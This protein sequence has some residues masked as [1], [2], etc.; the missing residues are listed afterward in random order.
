MAFDFQAARSA[1]YSDA[2]IASH[3]AKESGSKFDVDG[4]LKAGYT[5]EEIAQHLA[6]SKDRSFTSA[7][8]EGV[9]NVLAGGAETAEQLIGKT[10]RGDKIKAA[11][12]ALRPDG[13]ENARLYS[14]KEGFTPSQAPRVIAENAPQLAA[15]I[16]AYRLGSRAHPVAG[17]LAAGAA[18]LGMNYGNEVKRS[19]EARA[20]GSA[21]E[22]QDRLR[23]AA[24]S[25][26]AAALDVYGARGLAARNAAQGLGA[27][28]VANA[29]GDLAMKVGREAGTEAAQERLQQVGRTIGTEGGVRTSNE[30]LINAGLSG[31]VTAGAIGASRAVRDANS[32]VRLRE[33][34][35]DNA[36]ASTAVAE[37][38]RA[39][40]G[41]DL[42][43]TRAAAKAV[44][45]VAMD[46]RTELQ[47]EAQAA[48]QAGTLPDDTRAALR[49]ATAGRE[50]NEGDY[51]TL[52]AAPA[53]IQELARQSSVLARLKTQNKGTEDNFKGGLSARA[54]K[55]VRLIQNPIGASTA[56]GLGAL[57]LASNAAA[58]FT[59]GPASAAAIGAGYAGARALDRFTG[60]R[61]PVQRFA[62]RFPNAYPPAAA[63]PVVVG[64]P[65]PAPVQPGPA[66]VVAGGPQPGPAPAAPLAPPPVGPWN[67]PPRPNVGTYGKAPRPPAPA[68]PPPAPAPVDPSVLSPEV[69]AAAK[70]TAWRMKMREQSQAA[71]AKAAG[72]REAEALAAT[73]P[74]LE[75]VGGAQ[76]V[77]NPAMG[78][79]LREYISTA[80]AKKKITAQPEDDT[81]AQAEAILAGDELPAFL[82]L[83]ERSLPPA[84]TARQAVMKVTKSNGKVKEKTKTVAVPPQE[85]APPPVVEQALAPTP[86]APL[87]IPPKINGPA[88]AAPPM[89]GL[90]LRAYQAIIDKANAEGR[91][92]GDGRVSPA[93][94][95]EKEADAIVAKIDADDKIRTTTAR[96]KAGVVRN[97]TAVN[98]AVRNVAKE[99]GTPAK[100]LSKLLK[101]VETAKGARDALKEFTAKYPQA[102]DAVK[103]YF[104]KDMV[105]VVW[106]K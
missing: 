51:D 40:S 91:T 94:K 74:M 93:P 55:T 100:E 20:P 39:A 45:D 57:G 18:S 10:E 2:E 5:A 64:A 33:F 84:I 41:D 73:S 98:V 9:G 25:I 23:A 72:S 50:L 53:N 65:P 59:A 44:T 3:L 85:V 15:T 43:N 42:R 7:I 96:T 58:M 47:Q 78:K 82:P 22:T 70:A 104:H 49:R 77:S 89:S 102:A 63:A 27:R 68:A 75:E 13:Y 19:A 31:G 17:A 61:S 21:P 29:A 34:G 48:R 83:R 105:K 60:A 86:S 66:P 6:P 28:G 71:A 36:D 54:E 56:I 92:P 12:E 35:G 46:L 62:E 79:R 101:G 38:L 80:N 8:R 76:A 87:V 67:P 103:K 11:G 1:G 14:D 81:E 24:Y 37:R 88:P 32:A 99:S 30:D 106:K 52:A 90:R 97:L 69:L 26:P 4:A 16:A 95:I